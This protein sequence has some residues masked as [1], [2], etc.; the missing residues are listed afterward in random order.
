MLVLVGGMQDF[1]YV[2][3]NCF[4][5]TIELSCCKFPKSSTLL[6]EWANNNESLYKFIE[7]A[8]TGIKGLVRDSK[9]NPIGAAEIIVKGIGYN[10]RTT[11]Q[12]EYWRLLTPGK[13]RVGVKALE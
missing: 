11:K 8:H 10:V 1:N 9:N 13:Y 2:H 6:D 12:G 5:I 7:V 3:S 4:E